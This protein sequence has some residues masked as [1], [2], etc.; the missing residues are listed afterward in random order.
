VAEIC[1]RAGINQATYFNLKKKCD[2]LLPTEVLEGRAVGPQ[3]GRR[4]SI[5]GSPTGLK[6]WW[7]RATRLR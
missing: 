4:R 7:K 1:R 6:T 5:H 3:A 2:G